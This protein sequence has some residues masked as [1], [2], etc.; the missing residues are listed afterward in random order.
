MKGLEIN[1]WLDDLSRLKE[2]VGEAKRACEA[3]A[4]TLEGNT[5]RPTPWTGR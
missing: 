1:V 2:T 5:A 4:G 3:A